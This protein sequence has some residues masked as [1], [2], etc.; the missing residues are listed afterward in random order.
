[1]SASTPV[2]PLPAP[3]LSLVVPVFNEQENVEPLARRVHNALRDIADPYE[4]LFVDDGSSDETPARVVRL[5]EA[6]PRVRLVRLSRN[7]GHQAALMAGLEHARGQAAISLDGDLQHPPELLPELIARWRDGFH[8]VQAIRRAPVDDRA[9]K[10]ISS[11]WFY[12]LLSRVARIRV[13]PGAADFRLLSREALDAFL[14]CRERC[15]FN[16]GLVQWIGFDYCEVPYDAAARHAGR[17]KYSYAA[18]LRLAGDAIFSFSSWPLRL[19]GLAGAF[20]SVAAMGYLVWVLYAAVAGLAI[21][22]WTSLA[23]TMLLLGGTQLLVLWI[24]GEYVG[25]LYEEVKQRP[26]YIVRSGVDRARREHIADA[27]PAASNRPSDP[28]SAPAPP[29]TAPSRPPAPPHS[30]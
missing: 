21:T 26:I 27:S 16:R 22:G 15:R 18:M 10:R 17:T 24:L 13:T 23:A 20:L 7:F 19:A 8:V 25:R 12:S 5:G 2:T 30:E 1:M 11:G 9:A 3:W 28:F 14:A 4:L 6:D 29:R